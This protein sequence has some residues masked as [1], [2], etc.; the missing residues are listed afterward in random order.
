M[1]PRLREKYKNE[2]IKSLM[3]KLNLKNSNAVPKIE[4]IVLN[5]GLGEDALDKKKLETC[6]KDMASITGQ[7]PLVTRF[8]KSISN[9]KS[10]KGAN[11]GLKVTLRNDRMY[12]FIDRMIN[13][14][15]PRVKDFRGLK[16]N[17]CDR[18]GNFSFGIKEHIIFPEINFDKVDRIRGLDVTIV[19]TSQ[20]QEETISLIKEFNFPIVKSTEKKKKKIKK[21]PKKEEKKEEKEKNG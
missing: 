2:I 9:F 21:I 4:K 15:L 13:I 3:S 19:T 8:K 5:M 17:S 6:I 1:T 20:S 14:A 10:R 16:D 11:A 7:H 12:E 18:F